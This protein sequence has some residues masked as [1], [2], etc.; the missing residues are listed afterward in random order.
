MFL[1]IEF[2]YSIVPQIRDCGIKPETFLCR[3]WKI[4]LNIENVCYEILRK[5]NCF[6]RIDVHSS[7]ATNNIF[8]ECQAH[9]RFSILFVILYFYLSTLERNWILGISNVRIVIFSRSFLL[10]PSY[11][12]VVL[13]MSM[14]NPYFIYLFIFFWSIYLH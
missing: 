2:K 12:R 4:S 1:W 9:N 6:A 7:C 5:K 8:F 14:S 13:L 3:N 11:C 10:Y